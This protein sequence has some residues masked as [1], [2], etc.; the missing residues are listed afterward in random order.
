MFGKPEWFRRRKYGGWGL[1]PVTWQGWAY[2]GALIVPF[3]ILQA[4][5]KRIDASVVMLVGIVWSAILVVEVARLMAGLLM[6]ERERLHEAVAERNALWVILVILVGGYVYRTA[7][8]SGNALDVID[9]LVIV[10]VVAGTAV[11][12]L[13]NIYLDRKN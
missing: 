5:A 2:I 11:K 1:A 12:S 3:I 13:S 8:A 4:F 9:P 7:Q 10:A 6:D